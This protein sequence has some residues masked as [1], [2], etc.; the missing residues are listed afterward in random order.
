MTTTPDYKL[1]ADAYAEQYGII[2][3]RIKG[4]YMIYN[5]NYKNREFLNGKWVYNPTTYQRKVN[6]ETGNTET[7]RLKRV[8]ADGWLNV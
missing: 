5:Q 3:Y 2:K 6:L 7:T 8:V 4:K 1:L